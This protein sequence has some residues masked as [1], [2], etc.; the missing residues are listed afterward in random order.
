[1]P[2]ETGGS[3]V[4]DLG[5][6][7]VLPGFIDSHTHIA[8]SVMMDGDEDSFPMWDC[9]SKAEVLHRLKDHVRRHPFS[10]YYVAFFGQVEALGDE[11][12]TKA[13]LDEVAR[14]RPVVLIDNECPSCEITMGKLFEHDGEA[15]RLSRRWVS[16]QL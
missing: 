4:C 10:L 12:L 1:M 15:G 3:R 5:G 9:R 2:T 11:R 16:A 7:L 6:K 14:L 8:L 13:D